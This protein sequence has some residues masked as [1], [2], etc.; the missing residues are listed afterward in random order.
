MGR[1]QYSTFHFSFSPFSKADEHQGRELINTPPWHSSH[2]INTSASQLANATQAF[3][4][5]TSNALH[6]V[7]LMT[8][9][10]SRNAIAL[11]PYDVLTLNMFIRRENP[12]LSR[13]KN[14]K[15]RHYGI[16]AWQFRQTLPGE[17]K[18]HWGK[19]GGN[20]RRE[21]NKVLQSLRLQS[22]KMQPKQEVEAVMLLISTLWQRAARLETHTQAYT[23]PHTHTHTHSP[24]GPW[25]D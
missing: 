1:I 19:T 25:Y 11:Q 12:S 7:L 24:N 6:N 5:N 15:W 23:H 14:S 20:K 18:L 13:S 10:R 9:E 17:A 8:L 3:P 22:S 2:K 21:G 16:H 4:S